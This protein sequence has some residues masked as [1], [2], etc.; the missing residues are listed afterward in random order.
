MTLRN[1][2]GI[3]SK[4][5]YFELKMLSFELLIA[6]VRNESASIRFYFSETKKSGFLY[7]WRWSLMKGPKRDCLHDHGVPK[8]TINTSDTC[9]FLI[10][11]PHF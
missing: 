1:W 8:T 5:K 3:Y 9:F 7:H 11:H 10:L 4:I 2:E 6:L